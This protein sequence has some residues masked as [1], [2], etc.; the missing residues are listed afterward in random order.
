MSQNHD[1]HYDF[2]VGDRVELFGH[3]R[4]FLGQSEIFAVKVGV[5]FVKH[6]TCVISATGDALKCWWLKDAVKLIKP[7]IPRGHNHP[8]TKIFV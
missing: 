8:L 1:L 3:A 4:K 6:P 7:K 2:K 5:V